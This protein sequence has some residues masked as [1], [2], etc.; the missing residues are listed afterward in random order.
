MVKKKLLIGTDMIPKTITEDI[1]YTA[2]CAIN[3][4]KIAF[5]ENAITYDEQV[6]DFKSSLKQ[7]KRWSF[8]AIQCL[9]NYTGSLIKEGIKNKRFECFDVIIFYFGIIFHVLF[10]IVSLIGIF[11]NVFYLNDFNSMDVVIYFIMFLINY[12]IGVVFRMIVIKKCNKSIKENIWG[13]L[14][15]IYLF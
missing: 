13:I 5:N 1:E 14:L 2:I 7:R 4:I 9:K 12:F 3:G 11:Y 15:L 6:T 8:G 10:T